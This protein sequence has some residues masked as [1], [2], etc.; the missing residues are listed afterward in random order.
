MPS[1]AAYPDADYDL[2]MA[3]ILLARVLGTAGGAEQALPLLAE[4]QQRFEA[5]E[6]REPGRGAARMASA[7]LT[8]QGDC[9]RALGRLDE[10]AA[11]YEEAIRRAEQRGD[12]RDVAVGKGQLG[13]VRLRQ[14]RYADALAAYAD[15]RAS[16]AQLG[17]PA[18]VAGL[19]HQTGMAYQDAGQPAAAEEAYRRSLALA[20]QLG[21]VAGQARTLGQLGNLYDEALG[22]PE[23]AAAFYRQAADR[24]VALRDAAGEGRSRNNLAMTLRRLGRLDAARQEIRRAIECDA[25][26]GLAAEPWKSWD[27]LA[28]IEADAGDRPAAAAARERATACYLA[29]RRAGGE[30][31]SPGGRLALAVTQAL[32]AGDPAAAAALLRQ[33]ADRFGADARVMAYIR[34]L[35]AISAGSRDPALA[36]A[37]DLSYAMAAE[38]L[39]LI[40]TLEK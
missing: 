5:F 13:T 35:Q 28:G 21:D 34:A 16:F 15:A 38:I 6:T 10:A 2:A 27:I 18:S 23:E 36:A 11:A 33:Q 9:L 8:E 7:C 25:Q 37:P 29:Y 26:F 40:E 20:V 17:E 32:R 3:C 24:Y 19:W 1:E 22:R 4:A 14:L 31:H 12:D 30:N 39:F